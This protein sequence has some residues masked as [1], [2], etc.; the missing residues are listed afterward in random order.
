MNILSQLEITCEQLT[1]LHC[2]EGEAS[3]VEVGE[4]FSGE[5]GTYFSV[6]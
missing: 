5:P 6:A 2:I 4:R 3:E 1:H